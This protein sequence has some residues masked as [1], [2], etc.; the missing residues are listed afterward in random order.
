MPRSLAPEGRDTG[1][2][3]PVSDPDLQQD[4]AEIASLM[5]D[6]ESYYARIAEAGY[7]G[8]GSFPGASIA[9]MTGADDAAGQRD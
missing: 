3:N 1:P 2:G 4:T 5:E 7:A 6:A 8:Q 9:G